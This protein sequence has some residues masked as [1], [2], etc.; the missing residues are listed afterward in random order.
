MKQQQMARC[1]SVLCGRVRP[2]RGAKRGFEVY[3][4]HQLAIQIASSSNVTTIAPPSMVSCPRINRGRSATLI[5]TITPPEHI[6]M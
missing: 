4:G 6:E 2:G 1:S 3:R 5:F